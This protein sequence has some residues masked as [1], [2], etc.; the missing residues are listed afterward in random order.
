MGYNQPVISGVN[1]SPEAVEINQSFTIA[2]TVTDS[3]MVVVFYSGELI[4][5]EV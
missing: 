2:V 3:E 5:G 4:M 1:I